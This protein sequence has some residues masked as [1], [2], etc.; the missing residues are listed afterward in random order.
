MPNPRSKK[1]YTSFYLAWD[2]ARKKAGLREAHLHRH[3][4]ASHLASSGQ[5][6]YVV[7]QILGHT[8]P[9]TTQRYAHLSQEALLAAV[10]AG[11][12]A[13]GTTWTQPSQPEA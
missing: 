1:P 2:N 6:L 10:D 3:T 13:M 8:K 5:S 12:K 4:A 9:T 11:A 7:G